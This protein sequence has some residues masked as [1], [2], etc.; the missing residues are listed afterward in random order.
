MVAR[1]VVERLCPLILHS[2]FTCFCAAL[3]ALMTFGIGLLHRDNLGNLEQ[4]YL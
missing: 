3:H 4:N 1:T 2:C